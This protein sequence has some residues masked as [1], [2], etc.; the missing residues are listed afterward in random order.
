MVVNSPQKM[1]VSLD[2]ESKRAL[3]KLTVALDN[4][5]K[6]L[7]KDQ[8]QAPKS[9]RRLSEPGEA[10]PFEGSVADLFEENGG[11]VVH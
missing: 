8:S 6:A 2:P 9:P 11:D 10:Y 5:A 3:R 7:G 4:L 1:Q